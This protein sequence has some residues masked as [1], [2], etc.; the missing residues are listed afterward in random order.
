MKRIL[1]LF[2]ALTLTSFTTALRA[3]DQPIDPE[4]AQELFR[5]ARSGEKLSDDEQKYL[6]EAKR[7]RERAEWE[8]PEDAEGRSG[9][10]GDCGAAGSQWKL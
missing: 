7:Q 10:D 5:R 1:P 2:L 8:E 4:R 3:A 6:G 9:R